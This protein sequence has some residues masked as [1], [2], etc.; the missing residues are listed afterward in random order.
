ML[1][2]GGLMFAALPISTL[3]SIHGALMGTALTLMLI[4]ALVA[5]LF[6]KKRW[7]LKAHKVISPLG[8]LFAIF[9]LSMALYMVSLSSGMHFRVPHAIL[10]LITILLV[11][12]TPILGFLQFRVKGKRAMIRNAHRWVARV[13]LLLM[14]IVVISGLS[15]AGFI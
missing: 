9:G 7:W 2:F 11:F 8:A 15:Q 3:W 1:D 5:R 6:K 10:G 12:T 4:G 14:I 13:T